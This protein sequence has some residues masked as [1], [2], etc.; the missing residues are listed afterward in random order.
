MT[1]SMRYVSEACRR[2]IAETSGRLTSALSAPP[3]HHGRARA[4]AIARAEPESLRM[5]DQDDVGLGPGSVRRRRGVTEVES[6]SKESMLSSES[7]TISNEAVLR[8][9]DA[10]PSGGSR[11]LR[12]G[13]RSSVLLFDAR[14]RDRAH[15][16]RRRGPRL[17]V[18]A[19]ER[20]DLHQIAA[21]PHRAPLPTMVARRRRRRRERNRDCRTA[22]RATR[23]ARESRSEA[24]SATLPRR[25]DR[26][27]RSRGEAGAELRALALEAKVAVVFREH[28][29]DRGDALG[30]DAASADEAVRHVRAGSRGRC[31][32]AR[33]RDPSGPSFQRRRASPAALPSM[34]PARISQRGTPR[35]S[36]A[37]RRPSPSRAGR[38]LRKSSTGCPG[39]KQKVQRLHG[40]AHGRIGAQCNPV[41]GVTG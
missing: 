38:V 36:R 24:A 32:P 8:S 6:P 29:I 31:A 3:E 34:R 2:E 21:G 16:R 20:A 41:S 22:A 28:E 40:A 18:A 33:R 15:R 37:A 5:G 35:E 1:D 12:H 9:G 27:R 19:A 26:A 25:A 39:Q 14:H 7:E 13:F 17:A 10:L 11:R 30:R 4:E 23:L